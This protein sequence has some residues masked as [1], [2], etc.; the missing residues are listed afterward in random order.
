MW[1]IIFLGSL[2]VLVDLGRGQDITFDG[3]IRDFAVGNS[4][5][6]A[7]T[8][9]YLYKVSHNLAQITDKISQR[10]ILNRPD[11]KFERSTG[12]SPVWNATYKVNMLVPFIKNNTLITCGS[13][14]CGY[15]EVLDINDISKSVHYEHLEVSPNGS[16]IGFVVDIETKNKLETYVFA[17]SMMS[18]KTVCPPA[19]SV[20]TLRNTNDKQTGEIFSDIDQDQ[21]PAK[22]TTEDRS[23]NFVDGFQNDKYIYLFRNHRNGFVSVQLIWLEVKTNKKD[24]I[25]SLQGAKLQCCADQDRSLLLSSSLIP[26]GPPVLWAGVFTRNDTSDPVNTVLAIYDISPG[27]GPD[28]IF[29]SNQLCKPKSEP[30]I[31]RLHP[32]SVVFQ[33]KS[34]TSVLALRQGSWVVFFIGTGDGQLIKLAVDKNYNSSCP[35]VLFRSDNDVQVFP[36]MHLDPVDP[37]HIYM[38]LGNQMKRV[39]VATCGLYVSSKDCWSSEDPFCGWCESKRS[40]TFKEDCSNSTWISIPDESK[41]QQISHQLQRSS[42]GQINLTIQVHL[43]VVGPIPAF[44]CN[45]VPGKALCYP[46]FLTCTCLLSRDMLSILGMF[47]KVRLGSEQLKKELKLVNCSGITGPPTFDLC[48]R[49][50]SAGCSWRNQNCSWTPHPAHTHLTQE[51][52]CQM[53]QPGL[54]SQPEIFSIEPEE[55]SFHGWNHAL[56]TGNNLSHVT[57]VRIQGRFDCSPKESPVWRNTGS[58]L[59]FHIPGGEKGLVRVCLVLSDGSCHGTGH[60]TYISSP[61]CSELTPST[62][63]ESGGRSI[64]A[65]GIYLGLVEGVVHGN[66]PHVTAT[67]YSAGDL[68]FYTPPMDHSELPINVTLKVANHSVFCRPLTFQ[69]DPKFISFTHTATGNH[70]RVTIQKKADK[71]NISKSELTVLAVEDEKEYECVLEIIE[72]SNGT[73]SIDCDILNKPNA[74]IDF[75][76]IKYGGV[77][78]RLQSQQQSGARLALLIVPVLVVILLIVLGVVCVYRNKQIKLTAKMNERLELLESDI[79]QEIRQG[80]VDLQT[81]HSDLIENVGA[82]PFLDY[83]HFASR[84]FFPEGGPV[85]TSIV[86]DIG[87]D[88]VKVRLEQSCQALST[89]IQDQLFLTSMVHALEEQKNFNIKDKCT[90]ASLLTVALHGDLQYLTNVMEDLLRALMDQPSN[91]QPKLLL[92]RTESIVE[93]LLTNWMSICLYGFLRE[94]VGQHLFLLVSALTQQI[95]KGPVDSVT[96]KALYTLNEDWLLYQAP[97]FTPLKLKVLFAVG[98]EGEVSDPLE[99]AALSCD[100]VEQV[101][102]KILVAHKNKFGFPY[103]S[104]LRDIHIEYERDGRFVPLQEVD[105]SSEV[106]GDV[107]ML[108][109][110]RHYQVS[111]GMTIKVLSRRTHPPLSPQDSLKDDLN[112]SAKYFHLIDPE[113]DQ[114]QRKNPER[115]KLKLKEVHLTKLLS[116]KVAV[117][118]FVENLFRTIW[119]TTNGNAPC[120][121]KYFFDFLDV[122]AESKRILDPDVTHIWKT[123]SLPL[124]FWVNILKNPQFVF[125]MEKSSHLDSCL[126]VIAQ[127]FMDSFSLSEMQLGKHAATNKLLYAKDIPLY[128]QEVKAYYKQV[129]DQPKMTSSEFKDFLLEESKKHEN[130]FNESEALRELYKYMQRYFDD[131]K[132]KLEQ[133]GAPA[134]L[135]QQLQSV[136]VL[137]DSLK[138][139]SWD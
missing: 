120:V 21:S 91:N 10:G 115:K 116:T 100:T 29:C 74:K 131:I 44:A 26:G 39:P 72:T 125:D 1:S 129:K 90:V 70:L 33:Y 7:L 47:V 99:V 104:P 111:D 139:S 18:T 112:F 122:Q 123:N 93:K 81:D 67:N 134:E 32:K 133:N 78:I 77:E 31:I 89:L 137:F 24:T 19:N 107:T 30:E 92:R 61:S 64:R 68:L 17:A 35:R 37:R 8:D 69:P 86:K 135:Q 4:S 52:V 23:F 79:R 119:G 15:C 136:K 56:L 48:S 118:S 71:L 58:N 62:T 60:V 51:P 43:S 75:L 121:V 108:N 46:L 95:S 105:S 128:K 13:I 28:P 53:D 83:K 85:A 76:R 88:A 101:K 113:V 98:T 102:E 82:I 80:F 65:R 127:A 130:E 103:S 110:L 66:S 41:Q 132:L 138:S 12:S 27:K 14:I 6:Y 38:V 42:T 87:Q 59:T 84:I 96:E 94:S 5:L 54:D 55:V 106:L 109:T 34:M 117:H 114:D 36:R 22:I 2:V 97:D 25:G 9:D 50:V 3:Y 73:D 126:S 11:G 45:L 20:V 57:R 63:W 49:C 40:C 124:R 16:A